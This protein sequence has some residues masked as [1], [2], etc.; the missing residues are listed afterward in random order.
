MLIYSMLVSAPL[1]Q[2][3]WPLLSYVFWVVLHSGP[4]T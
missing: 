2:V 4:W 3:L 1:L